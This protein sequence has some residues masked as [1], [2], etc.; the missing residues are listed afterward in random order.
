LAIQAAPG[1]CSELTEQAGRRLLHL[2]N[3]RVD[4]PIKNIVARMRLPA[5]CQ[6]KTVMLVSPERKSD[7]QL[8]F[9]EHGGVVTFTVPEV[10]V[11]EIAVLTMK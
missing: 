2:V 4:N 9:E 8:P 7:L 5:G 1:L 6:V 10:R 11:Y 3:Y